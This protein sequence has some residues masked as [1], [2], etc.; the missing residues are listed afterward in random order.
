MT[1]NDQTKT[2][3]WDAAEHLRTVGE[4]LDYFCA[5]IEGGAPHVISH[6]RVVTESR[7]RV[8]IKAEIDA[9]ETAQ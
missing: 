3:K 7:L 4:C 8:L 1:R 9:L 5:A 6:A 2:T